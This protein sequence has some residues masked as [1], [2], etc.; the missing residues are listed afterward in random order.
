MIFR[1][2]IEEET[3]ESPFLVKPQSCQSPPVVGKIASEQ[4]VMCQRI[5]RRAY[6]RAG[7]SESFSRAIF[8]LFSDSTDKE[9][10]IPLVVK[11]Y[12]ERTEGL[13]VISGRVQDGP[14]MGCRLTKDGRFGVI[15]SY[16]M[17]H[18]EVT[19]DL[20]RQH[21]TDPLTLVGPN[22]E[23]AIVSERDTLW[24]DLL[25]TGIMEPGEESWDSL[26]RD[27]DLE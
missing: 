2:I 13:G 22:R 26:M 11:S 4:G 9:S 25:M 21:A 18:P 15:D 23:V 1:Q 6:T 14:C 17:I 12:C 3:R 7:Y 20:L 5:F 24:N 27:A 8:A 16:T 10:L 19:L